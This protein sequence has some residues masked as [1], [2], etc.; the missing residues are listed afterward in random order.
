VP[1][2]LLSRATGYDTLQLDYET[3][4]TVQK[5]VIQDTGRDMGKKSDLELKI[6]DTFK[7]ES[8]DN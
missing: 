7:H 3:K 2:V 6:N 8:H 4:Q 5:H 1:G